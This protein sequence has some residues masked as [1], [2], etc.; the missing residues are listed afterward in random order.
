M[1][2]F[3]SS[4]LLIGTSIYFLVFFVIVFC[5]KSDDA[6]DNSDTGETFDND[7]LQF[8]NPGFNT[9]PDTSV[10]TGPINLTETS[11]T[12]NIGSTFAFM[13]GI[14]EGNTNIGVP[15]AWRWLFSLIFFW[16]PLVLFGL[17]VYFALPFLH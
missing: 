11:N 4:K 3:V 12:G 9:N 16:L 8:N 2:Q 1:G 10:P 6:F 15:S 13:S 5:V 14:S 7:N 17:G